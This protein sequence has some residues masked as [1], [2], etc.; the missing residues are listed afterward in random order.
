MKKEKKENLLLKGHQGDVQFKQI[1]F[2]PI[3]N[4]NNKNNLKHIKNTPLAYGETSG[5]CHIL[6]GDV[7]ELLED[8]NFKYAKIGEKGARLQHI[9]E[10]L[11]NLKN[12]KETTEISVADHKSI[13]LP[14]GLFK[15][16]IHKRYNPYE[17]TFSKVV[18]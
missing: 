15:F 10:S 5:H 14:S 4:N 2:L 6:T 8:D 13:M 1:D 11:I 18:D 16:A 12:I 9:Q 3:V 7:Q 17:K